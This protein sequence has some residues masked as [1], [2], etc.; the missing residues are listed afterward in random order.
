MKINFFNILLEDKSNLLLD[1]IVKHELDSIHTDFDS[2]DI[3]IFN[4]IYNE[5]GK[6]L[7]FIKK[8]DFKFQLES[9]GFLKT[10]GNY[11]LNLYEI[12]EAEID[13]VINK[14]SEK[15]MNRYIIHKLPNKIFYK[16]VYNEDNPYSLQ[17]KMLWDGLFGYSIKNKDEFDEFLNNHY[18][19]LKDDLTPEEQESIRLD[20]IN[21]IENFDDDS[22]YF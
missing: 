16:Y 12:S 13:L 18:N 7:K 21:N 14:I 5:Y 8:N 15:L 19:Y 6:P 3:V 9:D 10:I 22:Y 1:R 2:D 20:V 11:L 4:N 17:K